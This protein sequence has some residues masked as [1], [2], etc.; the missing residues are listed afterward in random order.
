MPV[1]VSPKT[2]GTLSRAVAQAA[3]QGGRVDAEA[4]E[5]GV[6]QAVALAEEGEEQ[7]LRPGRLVVAGLGV[8]CGGLDRLLGLVGEGVQVHVGLRPVST[9]S[10]SW[11]IPKI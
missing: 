10:L 3:A 7:V 1:E 5:Q 2:R 8:A 11:M 6:D 9:A 4:G